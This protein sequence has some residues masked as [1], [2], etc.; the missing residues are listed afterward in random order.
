MLFS[1]PE[2]LG[3]EDGSMKDLF[4]YLNAALGSITVFYSASDY[5]K[6]VWS[7]LKLKK[8]TI[9]L[10]ILLGILVGYSRSVYEILSHYK[11]IL[12]NFLA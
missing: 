3:I 1:F 10:P 7:H 12:A 5:F 11:I 4:G 9:E 2:Y 6:N 8:I